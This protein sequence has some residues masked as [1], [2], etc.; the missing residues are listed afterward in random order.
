MSLLHQSVQKAVARKFE[1]D[2]FTDS[3]SE[4]G[5]EDDVITDS[6]DVAFDEEPAKTERR[7]QAARIQKIRGKK[8]NLREKSE[9]LLE[10]L[11]S[12]ELEISDLL[13]NLGKEDA[14]ELMGKLAEITVKQLKIKCRRVEFLGGELESESKKSISIT[15]RIQKSQEKNE[16][17]TKKIDKFQEKLKDARGFLNEQKATCRMKYGCSPAKIRRVRDSSTRPSTS[18]LPYYIPDP[19]HGPFKSTGGYDLDMEDSDY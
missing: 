1:N 8:R 7:K 2:E 9:D 6:E 4:S 17:L 12:K 3:E 14:V 11:V 10:K 16:I 19:K 5:G 13:E 18:Q 15:R